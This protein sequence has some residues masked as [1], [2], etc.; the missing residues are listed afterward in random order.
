FLFRRRPQLSVQAPT[1]WLC[2]DTIPWRAVEAPVCVA[3][4]LDGDSVRHQ[5]LHGLQSK[6]SVKRQR[7]QQPPMGK[8]L[9]VGAPIG[10]ILIAN[11]DFQNMEIQFRGAEQQ[12]EIAKGIEVPEVLSVRHQSLIVTTKQDFCA[13]ERIFDPLIQQP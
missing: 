2:P 13:T 3:R 8:S 1:T 7:Q 5:T 4:F 9:P 11:R 6:E 10:P 12:V